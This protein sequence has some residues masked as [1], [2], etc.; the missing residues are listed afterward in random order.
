ML[1]RQVG[2]THYARTMGPRLTAV[3]L[4]ALSV[5]ACAGES[6]VAPTGPSTNV[7]TIGSTGASPLTIQ[8]S[9]GERVRFVNND[10]VAHD[11]SS[12]L[13]PS[14]LGCPAINDVGFLSPGQS[15][16]SGNFVTA[17][18]CTYHD[19]LDALNPGLNGTIIIVE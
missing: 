19:H 14:H 9:V 17:E 3:F 7:V 10:S 5:A 8:I 4:V 15:R 6:P 12:D 16:E 18:I 1:L 2:P 13:H 11:M